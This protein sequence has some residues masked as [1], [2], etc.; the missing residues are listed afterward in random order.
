MKTVA[1]SFTLKNQSFDKI[2]EEVK[3]IIGSQGEQRVEYVHGFLT[4]QEV[5]EKG[6]ST[7]VVDFL[8]KVLP[9]QSKFSGNRE[10]MVKYVGLVHGEVYIIG[11]VVDGV[12]EEFDLYSKELSPEQI[13]VIV[14]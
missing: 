7:E 3:S 13:K 12:K 2:K 4:R 1:I 6:F 5:I 10:E 11:D 8:D 14:L 9:I